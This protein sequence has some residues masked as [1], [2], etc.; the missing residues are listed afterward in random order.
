MPQVSVHD[1]AEF[2][3]F[4]QVAIDGRDIDIGRLRLNLSGELFSGVVSFRTEKEPEEES[5]GRGNPATISAEERQRT[6]ERRCI[7]AIGPR[8]GLTHNCSSY[9]PLP[10]VIDSKTSDHRGDEQAL[11]VSVVVAVLETQFVSVLVGVRFGAMK[12]VMNDVIVLMGVM[13]VIVNL[14]TMRVLMVMRCSV[15]VFVFVAHFL[16]FLSCGL[17]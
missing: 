9:R 10:E 12:V 1:H 6:L 7:P 3:E 4:V 13:G 17:L 5:S 2:F 15:F 16:P 14:L 8:L 11:R